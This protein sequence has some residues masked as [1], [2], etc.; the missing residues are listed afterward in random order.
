MEDSNKRIAKNTVYLYIRQLV[1]MALSFLTTRVVLEKLGASD[2][3]VNNLVAGFVASFAVLNSIL[4]SSTRRFLALYIGK[5]DEL[6]LKKTFATALVIHL[7]VAFVVILALESGGL[8]F[9]NSKLNIE[10]S[11]MYAANWVFQFAVIG[12]FLNIIQTPYMAAVTA[13]ERFN[14][15][16]TMSIFDVVAKLA[17]IYVLIYLP[18]DK[19]IIYSALQLAVT[20]IGLLIYRIYCIRQFPECKWS[21]RIDKSMMKEM[22]QFS[23]WGVFG[24]VITV[25]NSQGLSI[26]LNLFFN[27]IMNAAR[28]LAQTVSVVISQFVMGF[29]TAAQP[30]LVKFYAAGEM[31]K[32][33]KLIFNVTQYTL[34]LLGLIVVPCLL[35][36]DYV[37]GLWLGNE[38]PPYTCSFVK[39]TLFCGIIYRSNMM[40][41]DGLYAIGRVKENNLYSV[42]VYLLSIPI[43]YLALKYFDSPIPAYWLGNIPPLLSFIIN[44]ILLSRFTDFP[45]WKFFINIFLKN[46]GLI[47]FSAVVPYIVQQFMHPGLV[48]FLTVCTISVICTFTVIWLFGMNASAKSMVKVQFNKVLKKL[49]IVKI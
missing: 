16:S 49:K 10:P 48:R 3:G 46:T 27:T 23:G 22:L 8:W 26:I 47:V 30:Q 9:L 31:D 42:P 34:F 37:I 25:V 6:K 36:I 21:L 28:G 45:G 14:I 15:Y 43:F 38:V 11:R 12:V 35:E 18:G 40:V 4:S 7:V 13:H 17:V 19:L 5:G 2:Y 33:I 29:L 41:E 39:I 1:I 20:S 32:F 44:M 24:H